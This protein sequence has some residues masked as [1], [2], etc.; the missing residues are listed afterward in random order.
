MRSVLVIPLRSAPLAV[1]TLRFPGFVTQTSS[2]QAPTRAV[3]HAIFALLMLLP[4][5]LPVAG[6]RD[7]VQVHYGV[8]DLETGLFMVVNMV[9]ALV[10]APF[11][12]TCVD[13]FGHRRAWIVAALAIDALAFAVMSLVEVSFGWLLLWRC[14]EGA[15]HI[16]ALSVLLA[17]A[18]DHADGPRRGRSMG[19]VAAALTLGVAIGA[20]LGGVLART[21]PWRPLQAAAAV[22]FA[23]AIAAAFWLR[24][25]D[26]RRTSPSFREVWREVS[27]SRASLV[28]LAYAFADR[29]TVGFFTTTFTLYARNVLDASRPDVGFLLAL[30]LF[31]FSLLSYPCG[32]LSERMSRTILVAGGSGLYGILVASLGWWSPGGLYV[33]MPLLGI[34]AA[35]M[36]VPSL[37]MLLDL[38][39]SRARA[40]LMAAFNAAGSLGFIL[41]P[42]VGGLIVDRA[43]RLGDIATGYRDA[44]AVAG[45][46]EILCVVVTLGII[47]R[48]RRAGRTT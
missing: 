19:L 31:P 4:L 25:C 6:L 14:I 1:S 21:D 15:A 39:S 46:S 5:T 34:T 37:L 27:K 43:A 20:P 32:R 47:V 26:T 3:T 28:P 41:G 29:F 13:R 24:E 10:A 22:L 7:F 23:L 17:L 12:G 11:V 44:F 16:T 36:Y 18:A 42:L 8:S 33:L 48:L 30:F 40:T 45:A 35:V 2:T 9:A 38:G